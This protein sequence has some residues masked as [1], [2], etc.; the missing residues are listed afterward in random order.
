MALTAS[1]LGYVYDA[2][3][4][5]ARRALSDATLALERGSLT[6]LLG[7]TGSGKSTL[8]RL[9]AGL[10]VPTEGAVEVDGRDVSR[11]PP[12]SAVGLVFQD[13]EV[14]LF[15]D[16]VLADVAF[17]PRNLGLSPEV[18]DERAEA[19]LSEV[20]LDPSLSGRSPFSLSGGEARR[21]AIAGVLAMRPAYLLLDEPTSG[22]DGRGRA[23]VREA[24]ARAREAAGVL[25]VTHDA[26]EFALLADRVIVLSEG[27]V[28]IS[29]PAASVLSE[30]G[31][32][33]AAG[34]RAPEVVRAQELA[35]SRAALPRPYTLDPKEAAL[36]L[37]RARRG[38]S[39]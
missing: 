4:G 8:L 30:P 29:G 38:A 6:L 7:P 11:T 12:G 36:R 28:V 27:M 10:L 13:P 3:T 18:A 33:S 39:R 15:G 16:T 24:L 31:A 20:G 37:H 9:C 32:L 21:T 14:Q 23:A 35:A 25:V 34:S 5:F 17:G 19:A 22:L 1:S 26:D 2:G